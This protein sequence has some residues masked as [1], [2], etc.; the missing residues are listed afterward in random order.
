M[1]LSERVNYAW[2]RLRYRYG[3][4]LRLRAPVD[5]SLELA[6]HCNQKCGYCY[7]ADPD[8][9]PF[10]KGMMAPE[11]AYRIIDQAAELGVASLKFNWKGE[12]TLN[13]AFRDITGYARMLAS[14]PVFVD[15]LTN[16]NFKF[17][18]HRDDI[19]DGLCHQ[20]KVKVSIDSFRKDVFETQRAGGVLELALANVDRFYRYHKRRHTELV[21]QAVRTTL[22][23]DE[24]LESEIRKRWP[25]AT[26]SIRDMV[27]GRV[28][29]DLTA[30][31][32]RSR[33]D[34]RRQSCLQ[35]HVR[36]IF[37]WEGRGFPC[38][39]DIGEQLCLGDI[40]NQSLRSIFNGATARQ[41]RHDLKSGSAFDADPCRSC[42]SF[43]T[44][45]GFRPAWAS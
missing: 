25:T 39:P 17:P 31:E 7:H 38:C 22:N 40:R 13:P 6:S 8:G 9:L 1:T 24:D 43:E 37:N 21:I 5:V 4:H 42:S 29:R 23:R 20:T 27:A 15:R 30:L 10:T 41:L 45:V 35:A 28:K 34:S 14:G 12:S 36:V 2:Y 16:S 33:D 26:V 11:V 3:Q 32:H 19:F 44:Y 18:T